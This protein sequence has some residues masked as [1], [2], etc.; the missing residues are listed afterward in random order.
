MQGMLRL[1]EFDRLATAQPTKKSRGGSERGVKPSGGEGG[2]RTL[3]SLLD[4]GALA[5]RC[6]RPLSHL[7]NRVR[8]WMGRDAR[9]RAAP[10]GD[11]HPERRNS[12]PAV[13]GGIPWR[14]PQ[15]HHRVESLASRLRRL[16]CTLG[17]APLARKVVLDNCQQFGQA[18]ARGPKAPTNKRQALPAWNDHEAFA[19]PSL[20]AHGKIA[21]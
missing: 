7:T 9:Q 10:I 15:L 4:Y 19:L 12:L 1:C 13:A 21:A 20:S 5:K 3:G 17:L 2:I 18:S 16:R 8:I 14:L 6:F 11:C